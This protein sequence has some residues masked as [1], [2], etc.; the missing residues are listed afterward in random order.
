MYISEA[1]AKT[2][3]SLASFILD[4]DKK[5]QINIPISNIKP[6]DDLEYN[7]SVSNNSNSKKSDVTIKYNI[8]I[9]TMHFIPLDIKLYNEDDELILTCDEKSQRNE[10]NEL[11][12]TTEDIIMSYKNNE[13]DEYTI[14]ISFEDEYNSIE[15]SSLV[16]YINLEINSSQKID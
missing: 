9:K 16:D 8:L 3:I 7:F 11:E 13:T 12:C 2:N 4:V 10:F 1:N 6:G 5:N 14:K 15:Y